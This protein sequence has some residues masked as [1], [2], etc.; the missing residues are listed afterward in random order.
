MVN[1]ILLCLFLFGHYL[2]RWFENEVKNEFY[3][4]DKADLDSTRRDLSSSGLQL[5]VHSSYGSLAK[6]VPLL[7]VQS[8]CM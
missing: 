4:A 2:E 7:G 3:K 8:S 5:V 1:P 6:N